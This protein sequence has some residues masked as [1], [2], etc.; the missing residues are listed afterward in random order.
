MLLGSAVI[1]GMYKLFK[2]LQTNPEKENIVLAVGI[3]FCIAALIYI[4]VKP[5]PKD[6]VNGELLADPDVMMKDG[7]GCTGRLAALCSARYI[8]KK[9][10]GYSP[11]VSAKTAALGAVGT[12][13]IMLII[14]F[15]GPPLEAIFGMHWGAFAKNFIMISFIIV[16]WP[17]FIKLNSKDKALFSQ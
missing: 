9:W 13:I 8:E 1:L 6:M 15:G 11:S 4:S 5:Y 16:I 10:V 2:Y 7:F 17:A 14:T 12:I 3:A